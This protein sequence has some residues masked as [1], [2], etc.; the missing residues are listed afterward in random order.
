M[1]SRMKPW[2]LLL[3]GWLASAGAGGCYSA[4]SFEAR[5]M[6]GDEPSHRSL[7]GLAQAEP[8]SAEPGA[9]G[10]A[11]NGESWDEPSPAPRADPPSEQ[12]M[13]IY[14]GSLTVLVPNV[15]DAVGRAIALAEAEGGYLQSRDG[16]E[17]SLRVPAARYAAT[18]D[19][20]EKFGKVTRRAEQTEDVTRQY[21][22]L[23][24]RLE[25]ARESRQRLIDLLA[26]AT[27]I[28]AILEI[29][30]ELRR[31]TDEIE[32]YEMELRNLEHRVALSR[33]D[34]SF[35]A[36]LAQV[37]PRPRSGLFP[38]FDRVG[39]ESM[40]RSFEDVRPAIRSR[41]DL[42]GGD[43]PIPAGF[44]LLASPHDQVRAIASDESLYRTFSIEES[45][46]GDIDFWAAAITADFEQRR[47]YV[48]TAN[49]RLTIGGEPGVEI[50]AETPGDGRGRRYQLLLAVADGSYSDTI[51]IV[52]HVALRDAFDVHVDAVRAVAGTET[53]PAK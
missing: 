52:E 12:R 29:E 18:M 7:D 38:W 37:K 20:L 10:I 24:I 23:G 47:G 48:I 46:Q 51:S 32:R 42:F 40:L 17:V 5:G 2:I 34:C 27:D 3:A 16:G 26:K 49:R 13:R 45:P 6:P 14:S 9:A 15:D 43:P 22:D 21:L 53:S 31:L 25:N 39:V 28:K 50:V 1:E 11:A 30:Q 4:D 33:I 36:E 8:S 41:F 19:A 44:L 35:V